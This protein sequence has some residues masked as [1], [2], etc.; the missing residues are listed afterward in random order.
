MDLSLPSV[1]RRTG[2]FQDNTKEA[3]FQQTQHETLTQQIRAGVSGLT[4]AFT[5]FLAIDWIAAPSFD[6]LLPYM[7]LRLIGIIAG[8]L[9]IRACHRNAPIDRKFW[10]I[11]LY[12]AVM[13]ASFIGIVALD[14][15][16]VTVNSISTL[17]FLVCIYFVLPNHVP[18]AAAVGWAGTLIFLVLQRSATNVENGGLIALLLLAN[19][20][21]SLVMLHFHH[22]RRSDFAIRRAL[23]RAN[24]QLSREIAAHHRTTAELRAATRA[25][26]TANDAKTRFLAVASHD[27][28]QPVQA[29]NLFIGALAAHS[30]PLDTARVVGRLG[31]AAEALNTLLDTLLDISRMDA[32]LVQPEMI[33]FPLEP[34]MQRLEYQFQE[35]ASRKGLTLKRVKTNAIILSDPVLLERMISNLL[36]NAI[37]YTQTGGICFGIRRRRGELRIEVWDTGIGIP[38]DHLPRIFDEF[39]Q[40]GNQAHNR[41]DG[42]GLGLAIVKRLCLLMGG[43]IKAVSVVGKGSRF[44][45]SLPALRLHSSPP[46]AAH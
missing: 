32:G 1:S 40:V 13:F 34:L 9:T 37:R 35:S 4:A 45:I 7:F 31:E 18:N 27:L 41:S 33:T 6:D 44:T 3:A 21:G 11:T 30:L 36:S 22:A 23:E 26:E 39:H 14:P 17:V 42:L 29:I 2:R 16:E 19:A 12:Q 10:V 38:P 28:R 5:A 20:V 24:E 43:T 46:P 8:L 25:A 15:H